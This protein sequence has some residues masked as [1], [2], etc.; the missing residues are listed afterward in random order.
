MLT[1]P[2]ILRKHPFYE[3]QRALRAPDG[4]LVTIRH[5]QIVVWVSI[6]Q[7]A[8]PEFP[9][10]ARRFPAVLDTGFNDT[11][12][13]QEQHLAGWAGL[14]ARDLGML[15]LL[16]VYARRVPLLDADVWLH[17]NETGHRDRL[18]LHPPFRLELNSGIG[19]CPIPIN[20][21]R[22]PLLGMLSLRRANLQ[23]TVDCGKCLITLRTPRRFW[24]FE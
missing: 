21:P 17:R 9:A 22:L 12:L 20:A 19:V 15:G 7:A 13:I 14:S 23:L 3:D 8:P 16:T 10:N 24:F 18:S 11:F 1:V 4:S 2:T 6:T 5:H